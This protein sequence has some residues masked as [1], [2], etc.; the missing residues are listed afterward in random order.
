VSG[1]GALR[2]G[3]P[4]LRGYCARQPFLLL[5][6][7]VSIHPP[8]EKGTEQRH[9]ARARVDA[10]LC[11]HHRHGPDLLQRLQPRQ[12]HQRAAAALAAAALAATA[13]LATTTAAQAQAIP[14]STAIAAAAAAAASQHA[15]DFFLQ[16]NYQRVRLRLRIQVP[17][18]A[19]QLSGSGMILPV[20][21]GNAQKLLLAKNCQTRIIALAPHSPIV[22]AAWRTTCSPATATVTAKS[23]PATTA[24]ACTPHP[25]RAGAQP[26]PRGCSASSLRLPCARSLNE[27]L[28]MTR[29]ASVSCTMRRSLATQRRS[30]GC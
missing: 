3:R 28:S 12:R 27:C 23:L 22:C 14:A 9:D 21:V 25:L 1:A 16:A 26:C 11:R 15:V 10:G 29:C 4:S 30:R 17:M 20:F 5:C 8:R 13:A 24:S 18:R 6:R 7:S 19:E 2:A